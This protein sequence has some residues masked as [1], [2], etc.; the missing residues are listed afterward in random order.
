MVNEHLLKAP[1]NPGKCFS[2]QDGC[3]LLY[4]E[5]LLGDVEAGKEWPIKRVEVRQKDEVGVLGVDP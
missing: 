5:V 1:S 4:G 2:E 3:Y